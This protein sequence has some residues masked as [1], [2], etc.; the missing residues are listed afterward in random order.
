MAAKNIP[1]NM[2]DGVLLVDKPQGW[3]SHDVCA[4]VRKNFQV[5]KVGHAGTLDPLA[6]GLL[7]VLLGKAT[8]QSARFSAVEKSYE[9]VMELGIKT[10]TH[11]RSGK[12][13]EEA[14]WQ[15]VTLADIRREIGRFTGEIIQVPPMV[16]ALKHQGVRLYKLARRGQTVPREGRPVHVHEFNAESMDGPLVR[17][18]VRVSKGTYVRTLVNDLGEILG[19]FACLAGLRRL[20]SGIFQM[21]AKVQTIEDLRA[22]T[23]RE[24]RQKI[25]PLWD[26]PDAGLEAAQDRDLAPSL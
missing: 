2:I 11:D 19:S 9:G 12:I 1:Y 6:T 4:F 24:L 18:S 21:G 16:S 13:V 5:K 15:Q 26:L 23:P 3:T 10:D 20:T 8:K 22:M 25:V 14:A 7:V 17:F